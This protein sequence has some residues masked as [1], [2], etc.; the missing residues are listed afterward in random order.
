MENGHCVKWRRHRPA[1]DV[2]RFLTGN[3]FGNRDVSYNLDRKSNK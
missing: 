2:N 3:R 1:K